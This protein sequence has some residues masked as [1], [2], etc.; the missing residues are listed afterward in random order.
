MGQM[1]VKLGQLCGLFLLL[2]ACSSVPESTLT[3]AQQ[4]AEAYGYNSTVEPVKR[5]SDYR[6][7]D[8]ESIDNHSLVIRAADGSRYLILLQSA[9]SGL[10]LNDTFG[11]TAVVNQ[12][13]LLDALIVRSAKGPERCAISKMYRLQPLDPA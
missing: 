12:L 5:I 11:A 13:T 2:S 4:L 8:F 6:N 1:A 7:H 9:C 3:S 10:A